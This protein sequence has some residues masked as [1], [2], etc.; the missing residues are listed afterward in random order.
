M[1]NKF[2][3]GD[4]DLSDY[5]FYFNVIQKLDDTGQLGL[6]I[7]IVNETNIRV[8][9]KKVLEIFAHHFSSRIS[10]LEYQKL[11]QKIH[12]GRLDKTIQQNRYTIDFDYAIN[13]FFDGFILIK[14]TIYNNFKEI[15]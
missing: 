12:K 2:L 13:I 14:D 3:L 11:E 5:I 7:L 15:F 1:I 8:M 4:Y 9:Y 6:G 10:Q